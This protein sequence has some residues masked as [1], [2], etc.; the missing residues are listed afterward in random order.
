MPNLTPAQAKLADE[1]RASILMHA[2]N[3]G[4]HVHIAAM[5]KIEYSTWW[6]SLHRNA[7][8]MQDDMAR[9]ALYMKT[10]GNLEPLRLVADFCGYFLE[11]KPM[12]EDDG[13][14][15]RHEVIELNKDAGDV[16]M[17]VENALE[18]GNLDNNEKKYLRRKINHIK[19]HA[20]EMDAKI[21]GAGK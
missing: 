1:I 20:E 2:A 21:E 9:L 7:N 16:G 19:E 11:R 13:H 12:F 14:D 5:M 4:G 3:N 10:T 17:D 15:L 6:N 8:P 18:D